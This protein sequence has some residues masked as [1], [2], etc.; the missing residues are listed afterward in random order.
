MR[1]HLYLSSFLIPY[2]FLLFQPFLQ[3]H[4][5]GFISSTVFPKNGVTTCTLSSYQETLKLLLDVAVSVSLV[6]VVYRKLPGY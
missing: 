5:N 4:F 1:S 6:L 2:F 3:Y